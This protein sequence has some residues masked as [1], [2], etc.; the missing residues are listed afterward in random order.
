MSSIDDSIWNQSL[1]IE[2]IPSLPDNAYEILRA[3]ITADEHAYA[4]YTANQFGVADMYDGALQDVDGLIEASMLAG[5][6]NQTPRLMATLKRMRGRGWPIQ[7]FEGWFAQKAISSEI[8]AAALLSERAVNALLQTPEYMLGTKSEQALLRRTAS[9]NIS[10]LKINN[11]SQHARSIQIGAWHKTRERFFRFVEAFRKDMDSMGWKMS[12]RMPIAMIPAAR[13]DLLSSSATAGI[14]MVEAYQTATMNELMTQVF[15]A[16]LTEAIFQQMVGGH[17]PAIANRNE[18]LYWDSLAAY[19]SAYNADYNIHMAIIPANLPPWLLYN[20]LH[21]APFYLSVEQCGAYTEQSILYWDIG[22]NH[23][24]KVQPEYRASLFT[25][26]MEL[27]YLG[28]SLW[29]AQ[30]RLGTGHKIPQWTDAPMNP[31][32]IRWYLEL[33]ARFTD[34]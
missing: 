2:E 11:I 19:A 23:L 5:E 20:H 16:G 22:P 25:R 33:L 17:T 31:T 13:N 29:A 4:I 26:K 3:S 28:V 32:T 15:D 8:D 1:G 7:E 18:F 21:S 34:A 10:E 30:I 14:P 9:V 12:L 24:D 27:L 6:F